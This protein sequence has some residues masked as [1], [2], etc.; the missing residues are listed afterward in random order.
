MMVWIKGA[1]SFRWWRMEKRTVFCQKNDCQTL[2]EGP[3][4]HGWL[5]G[6]NQLLVESPRR[7]DF[8]RLG[9]PPFLQGSLL[10]QKLICVHEPAV[11][12]NEVVKN[13][14]VEQKLMP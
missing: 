8:G 1:Y 9:E 3:K 2:D 6:A 12:K 13:S 7:G 4:N 5:M 14:N 10:R 11:P